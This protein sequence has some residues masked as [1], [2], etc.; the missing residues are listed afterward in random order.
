MKK[1][2]N[3]KKALR[4]PW[5]VENQFRTLRGTAFE[6]CAFC[7]GCAKEIEPDGRMKCSRC[8]ATPVP[9]TEEQAKQCDGTKP[10]PFN[11]KNHSPRHRI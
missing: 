10:P 6:D 9:I 8:E 5:T 7:P 4:Y 11:R 1:K 2:V 3:G